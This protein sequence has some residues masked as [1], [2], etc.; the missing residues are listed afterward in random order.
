M[1]MKRLQIYIDQ[2]LD[3]VLAVEANRRKVSKAALI[4]EAVGDRLGRSKPP[5]HDPLDDLVGDC[6]DFEGGE[7]DE[8]VYEWGRS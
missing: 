7:I 2:D 8:V 1:A 4:R 5:G 6:P 3:E